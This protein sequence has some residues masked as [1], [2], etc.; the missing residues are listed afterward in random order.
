MADL[1]LGSSTILL[2]DSQKPMRQAL[3]SSIRAMKDSGGLEILEAE[4]GALALHALVSHGKPV[5]LAIIDWEMQPLDGKVFLTMLRNDK[6]YQAYQKLPVI[7]TTSHASSQ[8]T[9]AALTLG[10]H[11]VVPKPLIPADMFKRMTAILNDTSGFIQ[12]DDAL[13]KGKPFIGPLT[14]WSAEQ[15]IRSAQTE[16]RRIIKL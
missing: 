11:T 1:T 13:G 4:D 2:A 3:K 16:K 9:M 12:V 6:D 15:F 7:I 14:R 8:E 10:A 5:H